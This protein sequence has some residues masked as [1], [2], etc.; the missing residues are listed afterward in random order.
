MKSADIYVG[1]LDDRKVQRAIRRSGDAIVTAYLAVVLGSVRDERPVSLADELPLHLDE[2]RDELLE[3]LVGVGLLD[4]DGRIPASSWEKHLATA[5]AGA[6][7]KRE[8]DR[9]SYARR[10]TGGRPADARRTRGPVPSLPVPSA[11][12][13][14]NGKGNLSSSARATTPAGAGAPS[15]SHALQDDGEI[16]DGWRLREDVEPIVVNDDGTVQ[17]LDVVD[18]LDPAGFVDSFGTRWRF[19]AERHAF[20]EVGT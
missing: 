17:E 8:R 15:S 9:Q 14:R 19:N 4:A 13:E 20:E 6:E 12:T 18:V 7:R 5:V 3:T 11:P 1:F 10:T 2:R 16:P